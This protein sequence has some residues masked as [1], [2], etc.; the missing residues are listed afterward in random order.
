M[1]SGLPKNKK[2]CI[3]LQTVQVFGMAISNIFF[4]SL[5]GFFTNSFSGTRN[6]L[7]YKDKLQLPAKIILI[8]LTLVISIVFNNVGLF[9][10]CPIASFIIFTLWGDTKNVTHFKL[11]VIVSNLLWMMHDLYVM[12]YVGVVFNVFGTITNLV[13]IYRLKKDSLK[14]VNS[15]QQT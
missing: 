9:V 12:S 5:P 8:T 15:K 3:A 2:F 7:I 13:G 4:S 1:L 11:I 6:I 10:L 14:K